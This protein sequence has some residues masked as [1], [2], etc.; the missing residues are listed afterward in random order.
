M[1]LYKTMSHLSH[2]SKIYVE[3][4][5][6]VFGH[7]NIFPAFFFVYYKEILTEIIISI[8]YDNT[9]DRGNSL[10]IVTHQL[11][12]NTSNVDDPEFQLNQFLVIADNFLVLII[13]SIQLMI[14]S[15]IAW[16]IPNIYHLFID[17][18]KKIIK[19]HFKDSKA[20]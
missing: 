10:G 19:N 1:L 2:Y 12:F 20:H 7:L 14:R 13:I 16:E 15:L 18:I 11:L 17:D 4:K 9:L 5:K 3:F 8:K 6:L